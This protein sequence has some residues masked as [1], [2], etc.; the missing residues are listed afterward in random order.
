M[1]TMDTDSDQYNAWNPG[2]TSDIPVHLLPK[3]TLFDQNNSHVTYEQAKSSA[4]FCGLKPFEMNAFTVSRLIVHETFIRVTSDLFVKDGPNYEDL[5]ISLRGMTDTIIRKYISPNIAKLETEIQELRND[6]LARLDKIYE[7]DITHQLNIKKPV[8]IGFFKRLFSNNIK[9]SSRKSASIFDILNCWQKEIELCNCPI[10]K[11][12]IEGIHK[13][14]GSIVGHRGRLTGEKDYILQIVANWVCND[15]G[16]NKIGELIEPMINLAAEREGYTFLP[17]QEKPV[18]FNV[19]GS[20]AAGKS[21]IRQFQKKLVDR[22]DVKWKDFALISPDYW[23][24]YLLDYESIGTDYKY[25]AMLTGH[26][27][28]IIDKKLD[29]YVESKANQNKL[30]HLLIDRF[31]FDSFSLGVNEQQTKRMLSRFGHTVFLFFIITPPTE[32]VARAWKRGHSTG[33]YKAVDDLLFHNVEAYTGIPRMFL[34][35]V[36]KEDQNIHF[37]FLDNSVANGEIPKTVA[38]GWNQRL[39]VLNPDM[40]RIFHQYC[41]INLK[42]MRPEDVYLD[43]KNSNQDFLAECIEKI[44]DVIFIDPQQEKLLGYVKNRNCVIE[45]GD[46][47]SKNKLKSRLKG[48]ATQENN[49]QNNSGQTTDSEPIIDLQ[50]E[51]KFTLG[52]WD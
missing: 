51:R 45:I 34:K 46:F 25:A 6:V 27:L 13:I 28:E 19:K 14:V 50:H 16:S 35:W 23:R 30:P 7:T 32:T 36:N 8:R 33:R 39:I 43:I 22:L 40:M 41:S 44:R 2:L 52:Q 31:R 29:Q 3:I 26:E 12:C 15:L 38:F 49:V 10:Q 47:F 37:E 4:E 11:A 1:Q 24:K 5:G 17:S 42:A 20:S 18:I 21:T 48:F 9:Q